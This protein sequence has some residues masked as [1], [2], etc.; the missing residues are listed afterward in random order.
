MPVA[1]GLTL[2]AVAAWGVLAHQP[3]LPSSGA[4]PAWAEPAARVSAAAAPHP[5]ASLSAS[6]RPGRPQSAL[7]P[8]PVLPAVLPVGAASVR[9]PSLQVSASA[10]PESVTA[11][12]LGVPPDP[13]DVGWW[14]PSS[15]ELVIDGHV[16]MEGVG[17][18]ALYEVRS[19]RPG[20]TVVQT[21][22][23]QESWKIS[24]VR[25]FQKGRVPA[26][27]FHWDGPV[28]RLV[29]VTCGGPF[30]YATHHYY[31]NVVAYG[32]PLRR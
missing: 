3:R 12:A 13:A 4:A 20:A 15:A 17:P 31:D 6:P 19:L 24:G 2:L 27:L 8:A 30:D 9:I 26:G 25:T 22:G 7:P 21:T 5:T 18:G 16:D 10:V 29:I 11:D 14:M 1:G 32:V 23:G 28:A